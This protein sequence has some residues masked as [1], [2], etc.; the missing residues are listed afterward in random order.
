MIIDGRTL[1][2]GSFNFTKAAEKNAENTLII[3]SP[4]LCREYIENWKLHRGHS[5]KYSTRAEKQV[6]P[7]ENNTRLQQ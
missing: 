7:S 1:I 4:E 2:T 3:R 6:N 5:E